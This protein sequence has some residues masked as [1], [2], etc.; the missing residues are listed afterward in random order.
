MRDHL[1]HLTDAEFV[2]AVR[3]RLTIAGLPEGS[4]GDGV[5]RESGGDSLP[6]LPVWDQD[7]WR[8]KLVYVFRDAE[9]ALGAFHHA[10]YGAAELLRECPPDAW[11]RAAIHPERGRVTVADL[12]GSAVSHDAEHVAAIEGLKR[13]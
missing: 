6:T 4:S 2:L 5:E 12:V 8:R 1:L 10:R 13:G 3:L 11:E 9:A 7:V